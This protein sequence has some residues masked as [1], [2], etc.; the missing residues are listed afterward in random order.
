MSRRN[1]ASLLAAVGFSAG[2]AAGPDLIVAD[3]PN[4]AHWGSLGGIHAYSLSTTTCNIG[5]APAEYDFDTNA[6]PVFAQNLYRLS[7]GRFEQVGM[8][9]CFNAFFALEQNFCSTC[10]PVGGGQWL[11]TGCSDT[12]SSS[13]NGQQQYLGP[14]SEIDPVTGDFLFPF[15]GFGDTGDLVFRRLQARESDLAVAGAQYF[16]EAQ[17]V[18]S[19]DALAGNLNNNATWRKVN[20]G[21]TFN[22]LPTGASTREQPAIFAW[23]ASTDA[24]VN[25]VD[26]PG[27]GRFYIGSLATD[28]GDGTWSYEYAIHNLNSARAA[29]AF[30]VPLHG[31]TIADIGFHDV[32]YH[33]GEAY[34]GAD[35]PGAADSSRVTWQTSPYDLNPNA[36]ALRWGTLYNFRFTSDMGPQPGSATLSMFAPGGPDSIQVPVYVPSGP[37][38]ADFNGDGVLNFFDIAAFLDAFSAGDLAADLTH[39]G[40]LNFFDVAEFLGLF[41]DGCF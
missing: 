13:I 39:D 21:S 25:A 17:C 30:A 18:A 29:G 38:V 23:M 28:N 35:W 6:H 8:S 32:D 11:G 36:N 2:A 24:V 40:E 33:S 19:D 10:V 4:V 31:S 1:L 7:N 27:D 16:I 41:S 12:H 26:V 37:C 34:D 20:V 14:R 3:L 15:T 5:D 22:L 9:F